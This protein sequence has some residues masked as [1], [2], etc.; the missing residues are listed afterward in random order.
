LLDHAPRGALTTEESAVQVD[1]ERVPPIFVRELEQGSV[2]ARAGVVDERVDATQR[3]G[4]LVD[5]ICGGGKV[6]QIESPQVGP[7]AVP[8]H[9]LGSLASSVLVVMSGDADVEAVEGEADSRCAADS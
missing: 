3:I 2:P 8:A 6:S 9:L 7:T 4:E 1:G 5:D